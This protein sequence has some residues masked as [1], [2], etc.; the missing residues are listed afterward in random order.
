LVANIAVRPRSKS[1]SKRAKGIIGGQNGEPEMPSQAACVL[2]HAARSAVLR[3][4]VRVLPQP[5]QSVAGS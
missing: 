5:A 1:C 2:K 4:A 3:E